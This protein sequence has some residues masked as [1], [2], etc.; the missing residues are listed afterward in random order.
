MKSY[1][2]H[3][4]RD[5]FQ[6]SDYHYAGGIDFA[7]YRPPQKTKKGKLKKPPN[8][9]NPTKYAIRSAW[10]SPHGS[11]NYPEYLSVRAELVIHILDI[12]RGAYPKSGAAVLSPSVVRFLKE[13][14]WVTVDLPLFEMFPK[15][16]HIIQTS[17]RVLMD[18]FIKSHLYPICNQTPTQYLT[19]FPPQDYDCFQRWMWAMRYAHITLARPNMGPPI[20]L[21]Q[22]GKEVEKYYQLV[23]QLWCRCRNGYNDPRPIPGFIFRN[24]EPVSVDLNDTLYRSLYP[25]KTIN[26]LCRRKSEQEREDAL[27]TNPRYRSYSPYGYPQPSYSNGMVTGLAVGIIT[28]ALAVWLKAQAIQQ[29]T[30]SG[31]GRRPRNKKRN[32]KTPNRGRWCT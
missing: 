19:F 24:D 28:I 18:R 10:K 15:P 23:V 26:D 2:Y 6:H 9:D 30:S 1:T 4:T 5:M 12:W 32:K 17:L 25:I 16:A 29:E 22:F 21:S 27:L 13:Q 3:R 14:G 31:T 8:H 7:G 11:A 20:D